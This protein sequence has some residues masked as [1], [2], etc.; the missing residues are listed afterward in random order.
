MIGRF[1]VCV[2]N[3]TMAYE[4]VDVNVHP[5]KLEVRFQQPAFV[6]HTVETVVREALMAETITEKLF[7]P[8][9]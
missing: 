1:P 9:R 2:L 3:L 8:L 7:A 5:N 4:L 6:M